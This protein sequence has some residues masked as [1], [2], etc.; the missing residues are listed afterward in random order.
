VQLARVA[1]RRPSDVVVR[2]RQFAASRGPT[3]SRGPAGHVIRPGDHV[4]PAVVAALSRAIEFERRPSD[5]VN[6]H[7]VT[8]SDLVLVTWSSGHVVVER[9]R[10]PSDVVSV[11]WSDLVLVTWSLSISAVRPTSSRAFTS[12]P[13][14]SSRRTASTRVFSSYQPT[15]THAHTHTMD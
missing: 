9:E 5:V 14:D 11:T 6:A 15:H 1:E 13:R 10:R 7:V 2:A 4:I 3:W 8:W 12:A